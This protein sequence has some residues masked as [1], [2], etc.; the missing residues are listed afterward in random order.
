MTTR[1]VTLCLVLVAMVST[2]AA[3]SAKCD[4]MR[5]LTSAEMTIW[6]GSAPPTCGDAESCMEVTDC[7]YFG[8]TCLAGTSPLG[9][10]LQRWSINLKGGE[11]A[12]D[13]SCGT[14][15]ELEGGKCT[16]NK[17]GCGGS[18][19]RRDTRCTGA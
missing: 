2:V 4:E 3:T 18:V 8:Y 17:G 14:W 16:R 6:R 19:P 13:L 10:K 1:G 12:T 9:G 11:A 15:L 5:V 7:Q